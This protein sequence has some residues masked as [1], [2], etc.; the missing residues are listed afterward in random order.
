MSPAAKQIAGAG[1]VD[2]TAAAMAAAKLGMMDKLLA[3]L[4]KQPSLV[5]AQDEEGKAGLPGTN[6]Y[7]QKF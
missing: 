6:T 4:Q 3:A 1:T 2:V 7:E 5:Q